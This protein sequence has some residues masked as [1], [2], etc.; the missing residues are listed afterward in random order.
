VDYPSID[1]TTV[2]SAA[3]EKALGLRPYWT[4]YRADQIINY[5]VRRWDN[6]HMGFSMLVLVDEVWKELGPYS[7]RWVK[8]LRVFQKESLETPVTVTLLQMTDKEVWVPIGEPIRYPPHIA[9]IP[10][11]PVPIGELIR[12]P[13]FTRPPLQDLAY[14]NL[15]HFNVL[16]DH[17]W[18]LHCS[19]IP[20]LVTTGMNEDYAP[21]NVTNSASIGWNLPQG[22]DAKYIEL[23][24]RSIQETRAE[25]QDL[26]RRCSV[27]GTVSMLQQETR[28][29]ET[30]ASKEL[31]RAESDSIL[32]MSA[33]ALQDALEQAFVVTAQYLKVD[34]AAGSITLNV[35]YQDLTLSPEE[36]S[37][38]SELHVRGQ[39]SDELFLQIMEDGNVLP[40]DFDIKAEMSAMMGA[41]RDAQLEAQLAADEEAARS[42]EATALAKQQEGDDV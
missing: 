35:D 11:I 5:R 41:R 14:A 20:I 28:A 21:T 16:S 4:M 3:H 24:G 19:S 37:M 13:F 15:A 8:Q 36:I 30:A 26:E 34:P 22:A 7:G 25:L 38:Y 40:E 6:G 33:Q 39:I 29:A 42:A 23:T 17:R 12:W 18:A 27:L 31:D 10:F 1:P 32:A 2:V 9:Q